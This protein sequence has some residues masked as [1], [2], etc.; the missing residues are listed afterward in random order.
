ISIPRSFT[1]PRYEGS[2]LAL[3]VYIE[4][5]GLVTGNWLAY[6]KEAGSLGIRTRRVLL[7]RIEPWERIYRAI[8]FFGQ[9]FQSFHNY[10]SLRPLL[11]SSSIL[12]LSIS[13]FFL[14]M[15]PRAR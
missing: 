7:G 8:T 2:D 13:L 3:V 1:A 11:E 15:E 12:R 9:I 14:I 4:I 10:S 5:V 6:Y